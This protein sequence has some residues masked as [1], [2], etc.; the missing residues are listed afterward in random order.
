MAVRMV[1]PFTWMFHYHSSQTLLSSV[2]FL[3]SV[4]VK[5][6]YI[7]GICICPCPNLY[8]SLY[9]F[10]LEQTLNGIMASSMLTSLPGSH[11]EAICSP[12][13]EMI[14]LNFPS[15]SYPGVPGGARVLLFAKWRNLCSPLKPFVRY[16]ICYG[17]IVSGRWHPSSS[18]LLSLVAGLSQ[19]ES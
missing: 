13:I 2:S 6:R 4:I 7:S 18:N 10:R 9:C 8:P 11:T 12:I 15:L 14:G 1:L 3:S 16:P 19:W 17:C 5:C